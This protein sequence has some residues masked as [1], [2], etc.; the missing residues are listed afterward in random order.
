[1]FHGGGVKE[2][3][4]EFTIDLSEEG[5]FTEPRSFTL[6][7]TVQRDSLAGPTIF[8]QSLWNRATMPLSFELICN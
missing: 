4:K 6:G 7:A 8:L 1:M 2:A 3:G 5:W